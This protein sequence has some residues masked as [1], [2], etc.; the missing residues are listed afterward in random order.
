MKSFWA[1]FVEKGN[2]TMSID[3]ARWEINKWREHYN[4]VRT[5]S[6]L[7]YLPPVVLAERAA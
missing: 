7:G 5:H 1:V 3:E 4:N 6:S 2:L